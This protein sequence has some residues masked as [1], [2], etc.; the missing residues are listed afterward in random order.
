[1]SKIFFR[2]YGEGPP[3][4]ILHGLFGM[5]DNWQTF[6]KQFVEKGYS[7]YALDLRNHGQSFHD[8]EFN[9]D[10]MAEDLLEFCSTESLT[11][12]FLMGHSLGGKVAMLFALRYPEKISKL[13]VL[14]IAPRYYPVH[15]TKI[16]SAIKKVNIAQAKSRSGIQSVIMDAGIDMPTTQLI[17]KNLYWKND[18]ELAWRFNVE[19][20]ADNLEEVGKEIR[21]NGH[22][23]TKEVL[24]IRGEKSDYISEPDYTDIKK[25]FPTAVILTAPDS[26]HWI[27]VDNPSWL[28]KELH[29]F[30]SGKNNF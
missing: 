7:V 9:L 8:K 11:Q 13:I 5:S 27:H 16:I 22:A 6:S 10:V 14:D 29:L 17:L 2:R 18:H 20:I 28:V 23:F 25:L 19:A 1:M 26:G 12:P 4:V 30:L 24:F 15:H 21:F 3:L